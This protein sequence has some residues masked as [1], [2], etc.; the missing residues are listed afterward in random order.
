MDYNIYIDESCHL[1]NDGFPVMAIGYVKIATQNKDEDISALKQ[2]MINHKSFS[3]LKWT[4]ISPSRVSLYKDVIDYFFNK[5]LYFRCIYN[6]NKQGLNHEKYNDGDHGLYYYKL[7]FLLI[8]T[9]TNPPSNDYAVF[10]DVKDDYGRIRIKGIKNVLSNKY[11]DN[12]PFKRFQ[13]I[14]SN[15]SLFM[16]IADVFLGAITYKLRGEHLKATASQAKLEVIK[17][18]ETKLKRPIESGTRP[19]ESKF[20]VFDHRPNE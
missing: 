11:F 13:N 16:Q 8:D 1:Q 14:H 4:S 6:K 18:I 3:E 12:S 7:I 9:P 20:N 15:D 2:L 10:I 17:H 19:F 5:A